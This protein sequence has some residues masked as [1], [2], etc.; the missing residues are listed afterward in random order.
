MGSCLTYL[1]DIACPLGP[2]RSTGSLEQRQ[3]HYEKGVSCSTKIAHKRCTTPGMKTTHSGE[4]SGDDDID[5]DDEE[6]HQDYQHLPPLF[7]RWCDTFFWEI[8]LG[9]SSS[10][11]RQRESTCIVGDTLIELS[12]GSFRVA[13]EIMPG[14]WVASRDSAG[15]STIA[16]VSCVVRQNVE[17]R[18]KICS[19]SIHNEHLKD[20]RSNHGSNCRNSRLLITPE[21]PVRIDQE[22]CLPTVSGQLKEIFVAVVTPTCV[23]PRHIVSRRMINAQ[24]GLRAIVTM[25]LSYHPILCVYA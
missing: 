13:R 8:V 4:K 17:R 22:W 16:R 19:L 12:D 1:Y 11:R 23:Y 21:H 2:C 10:K 3:P 20:G 14:D 25:T 24:R 15:H 9:E 5:D 7:N 6:E 18:I